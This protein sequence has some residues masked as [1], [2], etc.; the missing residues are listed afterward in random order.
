[1]FARLDSD[2]YEIFD[3]IV[4]RRLDGMEIKWK[5]EKACCV[6]L[7][8]EGIPGSMKQDM[9]SGVEQAERVGAYVFHA[10]TGGIDKCVTAGAGSSSNGSR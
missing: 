7:A 5:K 10:G 9:K 4:E 3:A 2:L 8:S 1:M 6:V